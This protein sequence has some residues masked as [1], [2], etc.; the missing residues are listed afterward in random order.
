MNDELMKMLTFIRLFGL[1]ANWDN[2]LD[3]A[4]EGNYSHVRLLTL[5]VEEEY[6]IKKKMPGRCGLTGQKSPKNWLWRP[7]LLINSRN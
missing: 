1:V 4:R 5:V 7:F 6:R 3:T 2:Y